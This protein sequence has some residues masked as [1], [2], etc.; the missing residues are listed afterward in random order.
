MS[1]YELAKDV[2]QLEQRVSEIEDFLN[3][4]FQTKEKEQEEPKQKKVP[5]R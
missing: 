3:K 4:T 1:E 5:A 2:V